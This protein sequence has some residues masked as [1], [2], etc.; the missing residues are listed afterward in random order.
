M[1]P[2]LIV[3]VAIVAVLAGAVLWLALRMSR[4]RADQ[5]NQGELVA[6]VTQLASLARD[7]HA[8]LEGRLKAMSEATETA[9]AALAERLHAQ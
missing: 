7:S 1:T 3:L 6:E 5:S 8:S 9:R 4:G 2:L